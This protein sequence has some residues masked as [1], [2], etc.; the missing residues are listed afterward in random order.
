[1]NNKHHK[2]HFNV[3]LTNKQDVSCYDTKPIADMKEMMHLKTH[4]QG[5]GMFRNNGRITVHIRLLP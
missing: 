3:L 5:I 2:T 4:K 1:M